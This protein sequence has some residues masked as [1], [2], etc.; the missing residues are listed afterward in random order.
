VSEEHDWVRRLLAETGD[1][2]EPMPADVAERL[3]RV[4]AELADSPRESG[5]ADAVREPA[6]DPATD[7]A[8]TIP[9]GAVV[10]MTRRRHRAW[11][12]ALLAAAAITVGGYTVTATG[13]LGD[14]TGSGAESASSSD[15]GGEQESAAD[16]LAT[17]EDGAE[18]PPAGAED[19]DAGASPVRTLSSAT[20]RQ[21][22]TALARAAGGDLAALKARGSVRDE[23]RTYSAARGCVPPPGGVQGTRLRVT[24]DGQ[25]AT[26]VLRPAAD[27][28]TDVQVWA[29]DAPV[30]LARV[31]VPR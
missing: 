16:G 19:A 11:G 22:A 3:D 18:Q 29:C 4:V 13:L 15:A 25:R 6:T 12:A 7:P 31:S 17:T 24:Y 28:R 20:L 27:G 14:L 1:S 26:A 21:D 5:D 23:E 2:P 10:P 9:G 30:R 8:T